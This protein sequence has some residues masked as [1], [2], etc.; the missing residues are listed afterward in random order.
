MNVSKI[1]FIVVVDGKASET[2]FV[3]REKIDNLLK[4]EDV[5]LGAWLRELVKQTAEGDR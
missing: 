5:T 1:T 3:R 4:A 2:T